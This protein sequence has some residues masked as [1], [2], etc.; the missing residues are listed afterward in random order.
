MR[1]KRINRD[2]LAIPREKRCSLGIMHLKVILSENKNQD[3]PQ[4]ETLQ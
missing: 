1:E 4:N 2:Q 3:G